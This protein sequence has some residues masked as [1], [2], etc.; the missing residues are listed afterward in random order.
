MTPEDWKGYL[1]APCLT[2]PIQYE[3]GYGR[4]FK[5]LGIK[6]IVRICEV[7]D[8]HEANANQ[9]AMIV[10][11]SPKKFLLVGLGHQIITYLTDDTTDHVYFDSHTDDYGLGLLH[12][13]N[14]INFMKGRHFCIG[15]RK[16][17]YNNR[18]G[19]KSTLLK[20]EEPEKITRFSFRKR[21]FLSYDTDVFHPSVTTAISETA[22]AGGFEGR[23]FPKQVIDLSKRI[24][25]GR[26]LVGVAV[27]EYSP[28]EKDYKTADIL[29]DLLKSIL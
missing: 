29:T 14:F 21:M 20:F 1:V 19:K 10:Q 9:I 11:S 28:Y 15:A 3:Q 4:I 6:D 5:G 12:S 8:S 13:G 2:L 25:A 7:H 22:G 16:N 26:D 17:D 24:I 18:E 23:M 27:V